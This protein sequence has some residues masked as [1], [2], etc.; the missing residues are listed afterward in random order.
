MDFKIIKVCGMKDPDNMKA[1]AALP[2]N[3]L[4]LIFVPSS[5]RYVEMV[6][7]MA[8]FIPDRAKEDGNFSA[9]EDLK[10]SLKMVGV[11]QNEQAQATITR[12]VNYHLDIIQFHGEETPTLLRNLR[13]T[14][15]PDI[16]PG[17]EFI[18]TISV[19]KP[20]DIAKYKQYEDVVDYFLFD[21]KCP[22]GG[23]SGEKFD[24]QMLQAYDGSKPFLLSG[25]IG[26]DDVEALKA[27]S[28]PKCIGI[29]INSRFET[30]PGIKD[31]AKIEQFIK[32]LR[33]E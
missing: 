22:G 17:I 31:A 13:R 18:K 10:K 32:T 29:D 5:P 19:E 24:W 30:A 2:I 7:S 20:E 14:I 11:F 3:W 9:E 26:P 1:V 12:V 6:S 27:F 33:Y 4:G 15:D 28:H 16:R 8:G 25:G 23:G 21:T